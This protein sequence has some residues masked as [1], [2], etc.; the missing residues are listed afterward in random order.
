MWNTPKDMSRGVTIKPAR[1]IDFSK[2][3]LFG[4]YFGVTFQ[5][6]KHMEQP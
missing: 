3:P 2:H 6:N 5:I 1:H 4:H